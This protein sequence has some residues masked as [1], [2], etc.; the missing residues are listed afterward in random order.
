MKRASLQRG[1][2]I[3]ETLVALMIFTFSIVGLISIS[4]RGIL[5]TSLAKNRMTA[6]YLAQEGLETLRNKRDS[7]VITNQV[8]CSAAPNSCSGSTTGTV[9]WYDFMAAAASCDIAQGGC[10]IDPLSL[11]IT[12]CQESDSACVIGMN[13]LTGYYGHGTSNSTST[14]FKRIITLD[15]SSTNDELEVTVTVTWHQGLSDQKVSVA[16]NIYNWQ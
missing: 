11:N 3:V 6:S 13:T 1:F 14:I 5:D 7:A 2:T 15:H 4:S 8:L 12:P 9:G 10:D 16:E